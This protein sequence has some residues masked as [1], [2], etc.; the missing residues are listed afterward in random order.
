MAYRRYGF[1]SVRVSSVYVDTER[2]LELA[3]TDVRA[4]MYNLEAFRRTKRAA[5]ETGALH[6]HTEHEHKRKEKSEMHENKSV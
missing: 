3:R 4:K 2:P 6:R 5:K 1:P